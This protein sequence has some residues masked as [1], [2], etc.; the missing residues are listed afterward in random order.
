[1]NQSINQPIKS[2]SNQSINGLPSTA[3]LNA[4]LHKHSKMIKH[5]TR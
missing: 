1:M 3:A 5:K 2:Q 4:G